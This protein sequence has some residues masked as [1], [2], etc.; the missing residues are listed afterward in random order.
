[1]NDCYQNITTVSVNGPQ[2][3]KP[4]P[5]CR[6]TSTTVRQH[7]LL[8]LYEYSTISLS[9]R[10]TVQYT[11]NFVLTVYT[12]YSRGSKL[13]NVGKV[14]H[15]SIY[16]RARGVDRNRAQAIPYQYSAVVVILVRQAIGTGARESSNIVL[17]GVQYRVP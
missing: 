11:R 1:M 6:I 10:S 17:Y 12:V 15:R 8:L 9:P 13:L 3:F 16:E 2:L 5:T 4:Y 14:G 7:L